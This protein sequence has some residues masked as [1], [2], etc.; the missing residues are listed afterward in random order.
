MIKVN[1]DFWNLIANHWTFTRTEDDILASRTFADWV[2]R[3]ASFNF[4]VHNITGAGLDKTGVQRHFKQKKGYTI[5]YGCL[6]PEIKENLLLCG[7]NISG[8][9]MAH[10][11]FRVMPICVGI[12][13]AAGAAA[14]VAVL[15]TRSKAS[16]VSYN[17]PFSRSFFAR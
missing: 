13:E 8:T 1:T 11:I 5:P 14:S 16:A 4:D 9:H 6:L 2:V 17:F 7:R 15:Q 12:G 3:D 10:S